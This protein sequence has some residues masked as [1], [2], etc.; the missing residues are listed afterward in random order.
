MMKLSPVAEKF[1]SCWGEMGA[2]WGVNRS[3]AQMHALFY[4]SPEPLNA[5][6]ISASLGV[7]RS[8]ASTSLRELQG[9]GLIRPIHVRGDRRQHFEAVQ[10]VWEMFRIILEE[11][12]RREIDPT[13]S[14]LRECLA[15]AQTASPP[16]P[17]TAK[18]LNDA[19]EFFDVIVPLYDEL[20]Q[21]PGGPIRRLVKLRKGFRVLAGKARADENV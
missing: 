9:W 15:E 16:D 17:H 3:A 1:I 13:V 10:D 5:E 21:L 4:L 7:A 19:L 8:N 20:R 2:R 18:R 14:V 11:R 12:K 6:E